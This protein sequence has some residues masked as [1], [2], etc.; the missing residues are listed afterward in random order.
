LNCDFFHLLAFVDPKSPP[1]GALDFDEFELAYRNYSLLLPS[2]GGKLLRAPLSADNPASLI[3]GWRHGPGR[4]WRSAANPAGPLEF[5]YAF[6]DPVTIRAVQLHQNPD[7]PARDVEVLI[8]TDD[9]SYS[10]LLKKVLPEKGNPS[11][12]FAFTLDQGLNANAGFLKVRVT[13]G[14]KA[15]H[16]G[17]GEIEVFGSGAVLLPD[18][19]LCYVNIDLPN[20]KPG[21]T[22][23]VRLVATGPAGTQ[24]GADREFTLPVDARPHVVT[25]AAARVTAAGAQL[26]GRL[27][28]LGLRTQFHFEYGP[29]TRYGSR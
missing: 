20:L 6:K 10:S 19:D 2:N 9:V 8:S 3:D 23:H 18:D 14:Y 17:L 4:M 13:S 11:P 7:W 27:N 21:G 24:A 28:P 15:M 1:R 12:N 5:V 22:Y 29:D 25:G 16:W 26:R